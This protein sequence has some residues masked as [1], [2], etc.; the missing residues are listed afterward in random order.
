MRRGRDASDGPGNDACLRAP[1]S[2]TDGHRLRRAFCQGG[3]VARPAA[4]NAGSAIVRQSLVGMSFEA[5]WEKLVEAADGVGL[6]TLEVSCH[7]GGETQ[8]GPAWRRGVGTTDCGRHT[9]RLSVQTETE[10]VPVELVAT[11]GQPTAAA[12]VAVLAASTIL[13]A[14][15]GPITRQML[16]REPTMLPLSPA[17]TAD[18]QA[19]DR[20][21][22]A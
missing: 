16:G 9:W 1:R 8:A 22:A 3:G 10:G 18:D 17:E 13:S 11:F 15:V 2:G 19:S 12:P 6:Q 14:F 4:T 20:R 7:R 5:T 21:R